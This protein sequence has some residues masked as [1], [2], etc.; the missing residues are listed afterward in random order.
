[1]IVIEGKIDTRA[2]DKL[3]SKKVSEV[4]CC[5][6]TILVNKLVSVGVVQHNDFQGVKRSESEGKS[7]VDVNQVC[8]HG[9]SSCAILLTGLGCDATNCAG[10]CG[11]GRRQ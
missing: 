2:K 8:S 4:G 6:S 5:K 7:S 3:S 10:R 1:M 9:I 11:A